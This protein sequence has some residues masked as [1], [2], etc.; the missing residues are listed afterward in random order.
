MRGR[1]FKVRVKKFV[2][3]MD[4]FE[5]LVHLDETEM[6]EFLNDLHAVLGTDTDDDVLVEVTFRLYDWKASAEVLSDPQLVEILTE[7]VP[8]PLG[9]PAADYLKVS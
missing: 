8:E 1:P 4:G 2:E 3:S 7:P 9:T 6:R 5:W